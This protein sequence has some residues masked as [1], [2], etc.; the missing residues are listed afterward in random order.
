MT[1]EKP[2][3]LILGGVGF[4]GRNFAK[5]LVDND[6]A[7]VIRV[8]DKSH[9]KTSHL[10]EAH[11]EVFASKRVEYR[12]ADLS[13]D[14]H[15]DN[16]FEGF[17]PTYVVNL[18]GETRFGLPEADVEMRTIPPAE[19]CASKAAACGVSRF[20]EVS[21]A[22]VYDSNKKDNTESSSTKPWTSV[23][24]SR[25]A[26]EEKVKKTANLDWVILRSATVYG[27]GDSTG[28]MPR[29]CCAAVYKSSKEKMKFLWTKDLK[30]NTV[31]VED[32]CAAIIHATSS[33]IPAGST[34]NVVDET[35]TDQGKLNE[36]ITSLFGIETGFAGTMASNLARLNFKSI[37]ND[38]NEGHTPIWMELLNDADIRN[39]P[40]SPYISQ[41]LLYA[42]QLSISGGAIK[43][44]GFK[45]KHPLLTS[46]VAQ[47]TLRFA[48][49]QGIFPSGHVN[50]SN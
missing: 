47:E 10:N 38:A 37:C 1:S 18:C 24:R 28:L 2:N 45:L 9:W 11:K 33:S 26:A 20:I 40:L 34:F 13:K 25:L 15:V 44:T 43:D 17:T 12:Q 49:K 48:E 6:L 5:Y 46:E 31:H 42:N 50:Y 14:S 35:D 23:A 22:Q 8:V 4:I 41:E 36:I 7:G 39:T 19:K 3:W 30:Y 29:F 32:L 27:E 21:T 16:A